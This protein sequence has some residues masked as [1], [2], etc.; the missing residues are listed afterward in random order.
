MALRWVL[1]GTADLG[2]GAGMIA[3][4]KMPSGHVGGSI[5]DKKHFTKL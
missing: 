4:F 2:G 5:E 1:W 3:N